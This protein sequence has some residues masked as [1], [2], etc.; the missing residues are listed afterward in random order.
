MTTNNALPSL[1]LTYFDMPGRAELIR[2]VLSLHDIPFED[3]RLTRDAFAARKASF[4]FEQV[5]TLTINGVEFAQGH[6]LARYVGKLTGMYPSD[7]IDALRVD[8]MLSFQED[9]V[10]ALIPMLREQDIVRKTALARELASSKLPHLFELLERRL[11]VTKG[12]Y[13]LAETLTIADV[14]LYVLFATFQSGRFTPM[15]TAFVDD[16]P[17]WRAIYTSMHGHPKVQAYYAQQV[18]RSKSE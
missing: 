7:P 11:A 12:T 9:V 17:H 8:E 5:P 6:S 16:Y 14:T 1:R 2:L 18:E 10:Q 4:P 13:V 3:E 15:D